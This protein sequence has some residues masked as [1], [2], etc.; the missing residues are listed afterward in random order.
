MR[1]LDVEAGIRRVEAVAVPLEARRVEHLVDIDTRERL[2]V[3]SIRRGVAQHAL[4]LVLLGAV[5]A[6]ALAQKRSTD[7]AVEVDGLARRS[8]SRSC[9]GGA[10]RG[11]GVKGMRADGV[12][13][14]KRENA[15]KRRRYAAEG[16]RARAAVVCN[17]QR[18][19]FA[20]HG[21]SGGSGRHV[22]VGWSSDSSAPASHPT[23][24]GIGATSRAAVDSPCTHRRAKEW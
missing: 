3:P 8:W 2:A 24:C 9:L 21:Q 13:C 22:P 23:Q 19:A 10:T 7:V 16:R 12:R 14:R 20:C 4:D 18:F 15:R 5:V 11:H 1:L 6:A 17:R